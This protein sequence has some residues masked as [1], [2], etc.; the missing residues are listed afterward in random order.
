MRSLTGKSYYSEKGRYSGFLIP[1]GI[2]RRNTTSVS[3]IFCLDPIQSFPANTDSLTCIA[4]LVQ[5]L[6]QQGRISHQQ[7]GELTTSLRDREQESTS[8]VTKGIAIPHLR[9]RTVTEFVGVIGLAPDGIKFDN[10]DMPPTKLVFLLLSPWDARQEHLGVL[11]RIV[12]L[13]YDKSLEF[14]LSDTPH[15]SGIRKVIANHDYR[16]FGPP[17]SFLHS[18]RMS[19][20]D[21]KQY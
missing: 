13:A 6:A 4:H 16:S 8:S 17:E 14:Q 10:P 7:I 11:S 15:P 12:S 21:I 5:V 20:K 19:K 2:L 9:T 18:D 1:D 3:S